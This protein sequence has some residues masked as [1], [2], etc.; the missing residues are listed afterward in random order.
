MGWKEL[1]NKKK[2]FLIC[3]DIRMNSG[4]GVV[5]REVV[6]NTVREFRWVVMGVSM[7]HPDKGKMF[8]ISSQIE[9]MSGEKDVE[10]L[11]YPNDNFGS[12]KDK[13]FILG[14]INNHKPDA[15]FLIADPH[16]LYSLF[17]MDNE[18]RNKM[19]IIYLNVWDNTPPPFYNKQ[20]YD[21][22]DALL[23]I[24][25]QTYAINNIVLGD[26]AK[27]KV[28][29]YI[30]HG[31]NTDLFFP[32]DEDELIKEKNAYFYSK[33]GKTFEFVILYVSRN[34]RRKNVIGNVIAFRKFIDMLPEDK[35]DKVC[36]IMRTDPFD[37]AGTNLV[38][39]VELY[40][41]ERHNQVIIEN[42]EVDLKKMNFLYN[43]ADVTLLI[44]SAEGWGL[45]TTESMAAGT[46]FI[47]T[48]TG[49][50]QDQM[51]FEDENGNWID[52]DETFLSNHTGKYKKHGEWCFPVFPKTLRAEGSVYTPYIYED[53]VDYGEVAEIIMKAYKT[54]RKRLKEMGTKGRE[55]ILSE[56]SKMNSKMMGQSIIEAVNLAIKNKKP[57]NNLRFEKIERKFYEEYE[58]PLEF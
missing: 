2:I 26:K 27:E 29:R 18:I 39:V 6:V 32:L 58:F 30:P 45:S 51:R 11:L 43:C 34:I 8:N 55:W 52:F 50:L 31:V 4:V 14:I 41:Q 5:G 33:V 24:S 10:V 12:P 46:P 28:I 48:V 7:K 22:C 40:L 3:D 15:L 57:Y 21:S 23:S 49:G 17:M 9:K 53:E 13:N 47:A 37:M 1:S 36:M 16:Y 25:K 56:E 54:G 38:S 35:K 44:S 20:W 42:G 19:P